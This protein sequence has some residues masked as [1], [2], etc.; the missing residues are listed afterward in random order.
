[1]IQSLCFQVV[2]MRERDGKMSRSVFDFGC[3]DK[4]GTQKHNKHTVHRLQ[5]GR[6]QLPHS[7]LGRR[8][9]QLLDPPP[10]LP[11]PAP[12]CYLAQ[13]GSLMAENNWCLRHFSLRPFFKSWQRLI[14]VRFMSLKMLLYF[15]YTKSCFRALAVLAEVACLKNNYVFA[16]LSSLVRLSLSKE[17]LWCGTSGCVKPPGPDDRCSNP[18]M[19][20][21]S[22]FFLGY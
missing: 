16:P 8:W 19:H 6:N 7:L 2:G 15:N 11:C 14:W 12:R 21:S 1:M 22:S 20:W 13:K 3:R 5:G 18:L 10:G 9:I 4:T 17:E